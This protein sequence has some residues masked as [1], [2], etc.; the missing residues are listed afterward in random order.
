MLKAILR[1]LGLG[2][3]AK[4]TR[5]PAKNA[6]TA[7]RLTWSAT[8]Q[9]AAERR[10]APSQSWASTP[11]P[12]S[13]T[14]P[15]DLALASRRYWQAEGTSLSIAGYQIYGGF[16]YVGRGLTR[17]SGW[18]SDPALIDPSLPVNGR[19]PDLSGSGMNYWPSYS[20]IPPQSRA[21]YLWWLQSGRRDPGAYIGY[22]FLYFYGLERRIIVDGPIL[23]EARAEIPRLRA[24]V[25]RLLSIYGTNHSFRGYARHLL[26][27]MAVVYPDLGV[28]PAAE[29]NERTWELP[30]ALRVELGQTVAAGKPISDQLALAWYR[31]QGYMALRTP[32]QRCPEEFAG[33][34]AIKYRARYGD[35]M[36]VRP[37]KRQLTLEYRAA[38][39]SFSGAWKIGASGLPDVSELTAPLN[40]FAA[41]GEECCSELDAYSRY[42]GRSGGGRDTNAGIALLPVGLLDLPDSKAASIRRALDGTLH[43]AA[44]ARLDVSALLGWYCGPGTLRLTPTELAKLLIFLERLGF[45]VEPDVRY[46]GP[47]I[48]PGQPAVLFRL[49]GSATKASGALS[50]ARVVAELAAAVALADGAVSDEEWMHLDGAI[51]QFPLAT[52]E[53]Q[54]L[55]A[56]LRWLEAARPGMSGL[57]KRIEAVPSDQRA[58]LGDLLVTVA[59]ADG[60]VAPAEVDV[61]KRAFRLLGLDEATVYSSIHSLGAAPASGPVTIRAAG[62]TKRYVIPAPAEAKAQRPPDSFT[63][64]MA[65]VSAKLRDSE[66]V[67]SLL[68]QVFAEQEQEPVF[69][70]I[71]GLDEA[72]SRL[73]LALAKKAAWPRAEY[74]VLAKQHGLLP[75]GALETINEAAYERAGAPV[76]EDGDPITVD[77][78]VLKE[79]LS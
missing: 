37:P 43:D 28:K 10:P 49:D 7:N 73:L 76:L 32:A 77:A 63:L 54:R 27:T 59:G 8:P 57:A 42:V 58:A 17:V 50:G 11:R 56:Y 12:T 71:A 25:E 30:L 15:T 67:A 29:D 70:P 46:N 22:V 79:T 66:R 60:Y 38:S 39:A 55:T 2:A 16:L 26:D 1:L 48:A 65:I 24:E 44:M 4:R 20:D 21:G 9:K 45:G 74:L 40:K 51:R 18:S 41:V 62:E 64:D 31:R 36:I 3:S 23:P 68:G 6:K 34:F 19:S 72:H 33:L 52:A 35:G 47:A 75:D 14:N 13:P 5:R 78:T 61:L 69:E 53:R